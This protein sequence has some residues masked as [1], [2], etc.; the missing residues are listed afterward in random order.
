MKACCPMHDEMQY[1]ECRLHYLVKI[2]IK[3]EGVSQSL[4]NKIKFKKAQKDENPTDHSKHIS[5]KILSNQLTSLKV[6][7]T[8]RFKFLIYFVL[9]LAHL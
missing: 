9:I 1:K 6:I 3:E 7:P 4:F 8:L 2:G 5:L